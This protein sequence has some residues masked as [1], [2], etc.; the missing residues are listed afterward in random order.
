MGL[1]LFP[2]HY[3][4]GWHIT[5]TLGT[6]GAAAAASALLGLDAG[7]T[8]CALGIAATQA[9]GLRIMLPNSCKSFNI[10]RAAA[11]GVLAA[12]LAEAGHDSAPDVLEAKFGL[13][14]VFGQPADPAAITRDLGA[15][16]LV[17]EISIKPYQIGRA[18]V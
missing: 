12:L 4:A 13:F 9:G 17:S 10:G 3:D 8:A 5:S 2:Q 18:H 14:G 7:R 15:R 16:Y 11:A 1:A 6:L